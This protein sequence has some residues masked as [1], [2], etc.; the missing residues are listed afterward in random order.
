M[1]KKKTSPQTPEQEPRRR[2][3]VKK[4][5]E[6]RD[7]Q[8]FTTWVGIDP[9]KP[10][11]GHKLW[12]LRRYI[13]SEEPGAMPSFDTSRELVSERW[14]CEVVPDR[15]APVVVD[16]GTREEARAFLRQE[17]KRD[18]SKRPKKTAYSLTHVKRYR[19]V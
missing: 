4:R 14:E 12:V 10:V 3:L 15:G 16:F 13:F 6:I 18:T 9:R 11:P 2:I 17:K 5:W 8:G 19:L 7:P 1:P